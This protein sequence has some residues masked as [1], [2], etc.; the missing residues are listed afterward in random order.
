MWVV[1]SEKVRSCQRIL[2]E[3]CVHGERPLV[4]WRGRT[5]C[6]LQAASIVVD[7]SAAEG[8]LGGWMTVWR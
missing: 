6:L 4:M 8:V 2:I 7:C 5:V 3:K 1:G